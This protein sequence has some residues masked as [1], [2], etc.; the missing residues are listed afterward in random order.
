[1]TSSSST[2]TETAPARAQNSTSGATCHFD[3]NLSCAYCSIP[4]KDNP[5]LWR[6]CKYLPVHDY[7]ILYVTYVLCP[8]TS[9]QTLQGF[10]Q[11]LG[12]PL[13]NNWPFSVKSTLSTFHWAMM[14]LDNFQWEAPSLQRLVAECLLQ[15]RWAPLGRFRALMPSLS[16]NIVF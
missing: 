6:S 8:N 15:K 13:P 5:N 7:V 9:L 10:Y 11:Y 2:T 3:L 16:C 4:N 14:P 12:R 1:M